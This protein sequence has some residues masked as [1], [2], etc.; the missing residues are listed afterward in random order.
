MRA[1]KNFVRSSRFERKLKEKM[2]MEEKNKVKRN[3]WTQNKVD[4]ACK[5]IN[6]ETYEKN[7]Q[8]AIHLKL[9]DLSIFIN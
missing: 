2:Y 7:R 3:H 4:T 6:Q 5:R 1:E 8:A 9:D